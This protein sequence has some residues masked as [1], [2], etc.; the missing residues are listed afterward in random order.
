MLQVIY[1]SHDK[2]TQFVLEVE[3][4][5][6]DISLSMLAQFHL[7]VPTCFLVLVSPLG[8]SEWPLWA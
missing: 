5:C 3:P 6:M 4:L 7:V 2:F 8:C 1:S